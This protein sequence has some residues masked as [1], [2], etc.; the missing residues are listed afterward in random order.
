MTRPKQS[1][2][3]PFTLCRYEKAYDCFRKALD[4]G[5]AA[6]ALR[7][8][9]LYRLGDF[10]EQDLE[11]SLYYASLAA[12]QSD[13]SLK[14]RECRELVLQYYTKC[15]RFLETRETSNQD[16]DYDLSTYWSGKAAEIDPKHIP[17]FVSLI[18]T[19]NSENW[20]SDALSIVKKSSSPKVDESKKHSGIERRGVDIGLMGLQKLTSMYSSAFVS[21]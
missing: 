20:W 6:P 4:R 3:H 2:A 1:S 9:Q 15:Q 13:E 18:A 7:L 10:V 12:Y 14:G 8:A 5:F 19:Y 16:E 17:G 11:K 21:S